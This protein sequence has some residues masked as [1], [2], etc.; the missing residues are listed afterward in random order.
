MVTIG[1]DPLLKLRSNDYT[2][3]RDTIY[4]FFLIGSYKFDKTIFITP[5]D[6]LEE[7]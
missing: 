2:T 5:S 6:K 4:E 7:N 3:K 1:I